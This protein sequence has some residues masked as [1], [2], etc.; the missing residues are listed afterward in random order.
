[1]TD[2]Y[3]RIHHHMR[4]AQQERSAS[5]VEYALLVGIVSVGSIAAVENFGLEVSQR[6][7]DIASAI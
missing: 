2:L 5:L 1:M 6:F 7:L 3:T 4:A